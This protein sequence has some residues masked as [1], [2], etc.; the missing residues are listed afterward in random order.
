MGLW[1]CASADNV[2]VLKYADSPAD[3]NNA[4]MYTRTKIV[5]FDKMKTEVRL[6]VGGDAYLRCRGRDGQAHE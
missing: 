3:F 4:I 2:D 5:W 1:N 6:G